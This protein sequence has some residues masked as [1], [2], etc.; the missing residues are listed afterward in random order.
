MC[1]RLCVYMR[2]CICVYVCVCV[3]V[4]VCVCVHVC[5]HVCVCVRVCVCE[6]HTTR[7]LVMTVIQSGMCAYLED[8]WVQGHPGHTHLC[9]LPHLGVK[10]DWL[11]SK[12]AAVS[13]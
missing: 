11:A 2:V 12:M 5:V 1:V 13:R 10:C 4:S 7:G 6:H 8:V 9:S 3:R